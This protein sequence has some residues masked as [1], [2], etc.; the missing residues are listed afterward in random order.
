MSLLCPVVLVGSSLLEDERREG[1]VTRSGVVVLNDKAAE[2]GKI[3]TRK[4]KGEE[5]REGREKER[6]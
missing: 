6:K 3:W 2:N 1:A 4:G 5:E